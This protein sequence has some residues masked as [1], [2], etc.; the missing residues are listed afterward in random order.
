[1]WRVPTFHGYLM[2][3]VTL[4]GVSSS[5]DIVVDVSTEK[6]EKENVK[7]CLRRRN[8]HFG[9]TI[10]NAVSIVYAYI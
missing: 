5:K 3:N 10:L 7:K 2:N 6:N 9:S 8:G 1:M 4:A